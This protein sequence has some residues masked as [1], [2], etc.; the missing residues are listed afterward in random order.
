MQ[1]EEVPGEF[2]QDDLAEDDVMLLDVWDQVR[3]CSRCSIVSGYNERLLQFIVPLLQ[4]FVWIGKEANELERTESVRC[5][6]P[7]VL[8][9]SLSPTIP[10]MALDVLTEQFYF[11]SSRP[12]QETTWS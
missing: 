9:S 6:E 1:I 5:G 11:L 2:T 10:F 8:E 3:D 4:V 7:L 12:A